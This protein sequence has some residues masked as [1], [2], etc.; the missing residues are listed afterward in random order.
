VPEAPTAA[1]NGPICAGETLNLTAATAAGAIYSWTG[2]DGF[3]SSDQNPS[4]P[5]ATTAASGIYSVT[6]TVGGCTSTPATT[7]ATVNGVPGSCDIT[8][9]TTV[10]F[11]STANSA[12]TVPTVGATYHW[13]ISADGVLSNFLITS[14][15][16]QTN[17]IT[18]T[19]PVSFTEIK[20]GVVVAL[21]A[22]ECVNDP[23]IGD[24]GPGATV[25][26]VPGA[27][28]VPTLSQWGSVAFILLLAVAAVMK[29]RRRRGHA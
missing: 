20:I 14:P 19:A 4:I 5:N 27:I 11:G 28:P 17:Q 15:D 22:C 21:G 24:P 3:A 16:P 26:G 7:E 25:T 9:P 2:P 29:H 13:D 12:S 8:A 6:A 23:P 18:W 1:N 10:V